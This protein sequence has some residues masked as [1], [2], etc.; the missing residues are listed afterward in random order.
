MMISERDQRE[1]NM[2]SA[3]TGAKTDIPGRHEPEPNGTV[4]TP[5]SLEQ[6]FERLADEWHRETDQL[7]DP[8]AIFLHPAYQRIIGLGPQA[9]PFIFRES[10]RRPGLW[11]W[12]LQAI[13]GQNPVPEDAGTMKQVRAAWREYGRQRGF[14]QS[15]SSGERGG[16]RGPRDGQCHH[17]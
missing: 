12:A 5:A 15:G 6:E 2:A 3:K 16:Y 8:G 14:L 11:H 4:E 17:A 10:E 1:T 9:L 7:S 13:T